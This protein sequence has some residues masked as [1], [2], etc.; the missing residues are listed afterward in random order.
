[1]RYLLYELRLE[2]YEETALRSIEVHINPYREYDDGSD[3][4]S[5]APFFFKYLVQ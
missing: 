5:D 2:K 1:M 4:G 3:E